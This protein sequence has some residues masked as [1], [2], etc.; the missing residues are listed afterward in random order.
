MVMM[1]GF[2]IL[3]ETHLGSV[4]RVYGNLSQYLFLSPGMSYL[5]NWQFI[6]KCFAR[7]RNEAVYLGQLTVAKWWANERKTYKTK[8]S[9][10]SLMLPAE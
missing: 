3:W 7:L 2:Q 9:K 5:P 8:L 10:T 4:K 6:P 1:I